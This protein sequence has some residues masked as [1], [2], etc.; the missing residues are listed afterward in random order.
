[1]KTFIKTTL[2]TG[3]IAAL[4][5]I[6][7]VSSLEAG[8]IS[9][10]ISFAGAYTPVDAGN[11]PV[12][13]L[14]LATK[15]N[16]SA[17]TSGAG[18][19]S[20]SGI[21]AA[22]AVTMVPSMDVNPTALPAGALWSVGGFSL[23][24]TTVTQLTTAADSLK[25]SGSGTMTGPGF[26][27]TPGLWV[28]TFNTI[29]GTYSFS[30]SS[31]AVPGSTPC[32]ELTKTAASPTAAPGA[33]MVYT[34]VIH[35]CGST[36]W[37]NLAI[38][39]DNGTP[40]DLTDDFT[41]ASGISLA[42]GETK[43]YTATVYLPTPLC[44]GT[45]TP[46]TPAGTLTTMVL[47]SGDIKV[48]LSQSRTLNDNVYGIPAPADGWSSHTY[49]NLTGSDKAEFRFTDANGLVVLDFFVDYIS[50][51]TSKTFPPP[52]GTVSY[53]SG[54]GTLGANGGDG[55]L[56]TGNINH[57]L[58]ATTSLTENLNSGLNGGFPSPYL[59][60]SPTPEA[61]FPNWDY[62]DRY[63][64]IVSKAAFGAAGF[65]G[66]SIPDI[67]NSPAKTGSNEI[68][69]TPCYG[70][71]TNTANVVTVVNGNVVGA[72][73]ASDEA[74]VCVSTPTPPTPSCMITPGTLKIDKKTVQ[75]PLKNNGTTDITLSD[76]N[77]TW[78]Q[79]INGN[80]VKM[81]LNG[82]FWTGSVGGGSASINT[83][84]NSDAN[85]RKI[86]KGQ[87][88]TLVLTFANDASK[89]VTS[90]SG[91]IKFGTDASCAVTFPP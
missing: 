87:T 63:T 4:A 88:K 75:L 65:G 60:N 13:D 61:S 78:D 56:V 79:A 71:V 82:D 91:S 11:N 43:T 55:Q 51:A 62:V 3:I 41:V 1:M 5:S 58:F 28:S 57:V 7:S 2:T 72:T 37:I 36:P 66:V 52:T 39:D 22:S 44:V 73:L 81:S 15:I 47:P 8:Q 32:V 84:F 19:G 89:T 38:I 80:L 6:F 21:P 83:G 90:Y 40:A 70:C 10:G 68:T 49:G 45:T 64:V 12:S 9:G 33:P 53:P 23:T 59:V 77:V 26:D 35:N 27:P 29:A 31:A 50:S 76:V 48:M 16:F 46:P 42:P 18:T 17:S 74:M 20:F 34:Y 24:L 14:T 30:Q 69:P 25:I 85:R 67:H 54:Y 86:A